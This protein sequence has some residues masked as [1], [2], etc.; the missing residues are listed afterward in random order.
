MN[1]FLLLQLCANLDTWRIMSPQN[2]HP[3]LQECSHHPCKQYDLCQRRSRVCGGRST[4]LWAAE[5][6]A[7]GVEP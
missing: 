5:V 6:R 1:P 3:Q 7:P 4:G 2:Y